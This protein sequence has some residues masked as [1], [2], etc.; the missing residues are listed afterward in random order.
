[1]NNQP[2]GSPASGASAASCAPPLGL[3]QRHSSSSN[4]ANNFGSVPPVGDENSDPNHGNQGRAGGGHQSHISQARKIPAPPPRASLASAAGRIHS[5]RI[6]T[7]AADR[8]SGMSSDVVVVD[9]SG[10]RALVPARSNKNGNEDV[11]LSLWVVGY[12]ESVRRSDFSPPGFCSALI[13]RAS[14]YRYPPPPGPHQF[15]PPCRLSKRG[16]IPR[17]LPS[18]VELRIDHIPSGRPILLRREE[19]ERRR[20]QRGGGQWR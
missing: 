19:E 3:R 17:P 16:P 20:R 2:F 7:T 1:M 12:G 13:F 4:A 11:D 10:A 8:M 9:A 14:M 5:R 18:T 15:S 6:A